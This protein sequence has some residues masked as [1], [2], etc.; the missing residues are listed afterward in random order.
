MQIKVNMLSI[1]T[2]IGGIVVILTA[3]IL[4]ACGVWD[5]SMTDVITGVMTMQAMV[6]PIDVSK[7]K[8]AG[9]DKV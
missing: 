3:M 6:L 2:K 9:H 8:V 4:I 7:I 1:A 5:I